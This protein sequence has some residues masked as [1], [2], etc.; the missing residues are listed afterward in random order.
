MEVRNPVVA[1]QFYEADKKLLE[2]EI[3]KCFLSKLGPGKM[4]SIKKGKRE[5]LGLV[6]PHAGY[7]YSGPV[8][9]HAYHSLSADGQPETFIIVGPNH[10]GIGS[11]LAIMKSGKWLT[12]LGSAEIDTEAAKKILKESSLLKEDPYAHSCEHSIEVQLPFLQFIYKK[13]KFVPIC[14]LDQSYEACEDLADAIASAKLK[15]VVVIA[16]SD[17]S[18]YVPYETAYSNDAKA[19]EAIEKLDAKKFYETVTNLNLS[20]CGYGPITTMLLFAKKVG[21]KKCRILKYA[22]SGDI[23]GDKSAVVGYCSAEVRR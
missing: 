7:F 18:H 14:M 9:A 11:A 6:A 19:L 3:K 8:A 15:D 12:P 2:E 20:V 4:S 13:I 1:G 16:S 21:A 5:V 10:T 23:L 22:T 17:F